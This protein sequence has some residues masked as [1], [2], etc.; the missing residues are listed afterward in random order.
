M[1]SLLA[2]THGLKRDNAIIL[3][4]RLWAAGLCEPIDG[5]ARG[6]PCGQRR[7]APGLCRLE[8]G[9]PCRLFRLRR[10]GPEHFAVPR[11]GS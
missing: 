3:L 9:R 6:R 1:R 7:A 2:V 5:V 4:P 8:V 10:A 11:G